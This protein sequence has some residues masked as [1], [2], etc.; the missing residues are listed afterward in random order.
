[1]LEKTKGKK[2]NCLWPMKRS[3]VISVLVKCGTLTAVVRVI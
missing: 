2:R 3:K 1:M